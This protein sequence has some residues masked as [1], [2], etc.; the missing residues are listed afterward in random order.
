M[1][2]KRCFDIG[3][4]FLGLLLLAPL[5]ALLSILIKCGSRGPILF[6][7]IRVGRDGVEFTLLKFRSMRVD[8]GRQNR[9]FEPGN[10]D[11]I[12][13]VGGFM[14]G[15]K[16]DELPQLWNVLVGQMSLVG[17]RPEVPRWVKLDDPDW[18][19]VLSIRPG[20]TDPASIA[21]RNEEKLLA[22]SD[23]PERTYEQEILPRKL[24]L[25]CRYV[26]SRSLLGDVGIILKTLLGTS[27]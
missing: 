6:R 11:R 2:T 18:L 26:D 13:G 12:T 17:P 9:Q 10:A 21:Y 15:T 7:Q 4:S 27:R 25:S 8:E 19:K 14:R 16:L 24:E 3:A 23:D 1:A 5:L 22:A 20:I